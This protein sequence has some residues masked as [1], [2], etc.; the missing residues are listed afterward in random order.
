[1]GDAVSG[2]GN[3]RLIAARQL[4]LPCAP[5]STGQGHADG[6]VDGLIVA[7]FEMEER[8]LAAPQ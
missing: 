7:E 2:A 4:V 8:G 6:K 1:M 5:A 3:D